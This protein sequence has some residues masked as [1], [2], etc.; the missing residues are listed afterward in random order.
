MEE[1]I[2]NERPQHGSPY[3]HSR[4]CEREFARARTGNRQA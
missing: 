3:G 1:F 2:L 4:S